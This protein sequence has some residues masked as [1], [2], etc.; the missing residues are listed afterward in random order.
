MLA[1]LTSGH[2]NTVLTHLH[3]TDAQAKAVSAPAT[4]E[5]LRKYINEQSVAAAG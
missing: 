5:K 2:L 1:H 3:Q 4:L